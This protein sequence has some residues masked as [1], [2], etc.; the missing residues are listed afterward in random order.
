MLPVTQARVVFPG[1]GSL[2]SVKRSSYR[3]VCFFFCVRRSILWNN[4][5]FNLDGAVGW[6]MTPQEIHLLPNSRNLWTSSFWRKDP[7]RCNEGKDLEMNRSPSIIWA[8]PVSN[9]KC[10]HKRREGDFADTGDGDNV[11][12]EAETAVM[13]S[14][15]KECLEPE[16][17]SG[18]KWNCP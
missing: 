1:G 7:C 16:A 4:L 6:M 13:K 14:Q 18:K 15:P 11:T 10:T 8:C 17:G 9:D 3:V 12:M 5:S 2:Q